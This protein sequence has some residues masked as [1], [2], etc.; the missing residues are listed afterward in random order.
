MLSPVERA[1]RA[2]IAA[3]TLH[4]THDPKETTAKARETFLDSFERQVDPDGALPPEE[5]QRRAMYARKAHF[6]RLALLSA[7]ARRATRAGR[8]TAA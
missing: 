4:A 3:Y 8:E 2:R 5:R 1:L 7:K 6:S